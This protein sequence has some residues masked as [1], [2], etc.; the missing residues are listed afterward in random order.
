LAAFGLMRVL[1][2]I[3]RRSLGRFLE[4]EGF[5]RSMALAGQAFATLLPLMIVFGTVAQGDSQEVA[6]DLIERLD[7]SG[8]AA[9]TLRA[10]VSQPPESGLSIVGV[11]LLVISALSF[12]R[13]MQRLYVRAWRLEPLGL[14]GNLWGLLWLAVF[15]AFWSLQPAV[16]EFFDGVV[17]L[18]VSLAISTLLW[19]CTPWLLVARRISWRRLLPQA[20][21]T[22]VGMAG[23]G[24][25]AAIYLPRAVASASAEFGILGV[26]FTLLSLLFAVAFVLVVTAAFGAT[27]ADPRPSLAPPRRDTD[28]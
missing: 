26:A 20:F 2:D 19:L 3:G 14:R 10:T 21:L 13:A 4:L 28:P 22:A 6:E 17:A 18:V 7:V 9:D 24:V 25:G 16:V 5:D 15:I 23:L 11:V 8:S 1:L 12:T 27:L